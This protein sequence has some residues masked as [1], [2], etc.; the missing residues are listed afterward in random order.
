MKKANIPITFTTFITI[1]H[2]AFITATGCIQYC[3]K[4]F[5]DNI[6]ISVV[7]TT[8]TDESENVKHSIHLM[9]LS[10]LL[11]VVVTNAV[12]VVVVV[13]VTVV[14]FVIGMPVVVRFTFGVVVAIG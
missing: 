12:A 9:K 13:V 6:L 5:T 2:T 11:L 14:A 4:S 8:T 3:S 10:L 7:A 1:Q